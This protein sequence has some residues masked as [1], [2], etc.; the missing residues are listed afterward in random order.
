METQVQKIQLPKLQ[1]TDGKRV[2]SANGIRLNVLNRL[3]DFVRSGYEEKLQEMT[4]EKIKQIMRVVN[5]LQNETSALWWIQN[6]QMVLA[7]K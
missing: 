2:Q 1:S 3:T 7:V 5:A 4:E 6:K